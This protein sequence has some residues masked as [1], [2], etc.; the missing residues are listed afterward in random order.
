MAKLN[1]KDRKKVDKA[2]AVTGSFEP[3]TPGKYVAELA[4]VETKVSGAGN[5]YW[6]AEFTEIHT[7]D[8]DKKPGRQWYMLMLPVDKM[9]ADYKEDE[10][11]TDEQRKE[12]WE[13]YQRLTAGRI[14]AF[15]EAFGYDTDSD[16]D[17][18][19]G[20]R[21]ILQIGIETQQR[22][23]NAGQQ[24]NRVNAVLPLDEHGDFEF[25]D[26]DGDDDF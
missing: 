26:D 11:L 9:P 3:L 13:T 1:A 24:R 23:A 6:N 20:D 8:G 14:K 19:I 22:G 2:E 5:A 4:K 16:T 10:A 21:C 17:E 25:G 7:L 12:K 15:F 18:M